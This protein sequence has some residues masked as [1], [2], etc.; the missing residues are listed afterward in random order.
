MP[1][2]GRTLGLWGVGVGVRPQ[3]AVMTDR[4]ALGPK[5]GQDLEI[6]RQGGVGRAFQTT[7]K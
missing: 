5:D 6:Q 7:Q 1:E 2:C 3:E 4:L